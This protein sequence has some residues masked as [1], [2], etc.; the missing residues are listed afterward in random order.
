MFKNHDLKQMELT[1]IEPA[2]FGLQKRFFLMRETLDT[3][4]TRV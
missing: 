4:K 1:G 3:V 2:T